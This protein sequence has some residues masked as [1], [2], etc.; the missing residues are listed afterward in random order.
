MPT[1]LEN[2]DSDL[3]FG[4]ASALLGLHPSHT[5]DQKFEELQKAGFRYCEVLT[6][7]YIGWVRQQKPELPESTCPP[8]WAE[9]REPDPSDS[10]IWAAL[11]TFAPKFTA[12][13]NQYGLT[14]IVL[15][16]LNHFEGWPEGHERE[17]WSRRKAERWLSL[18]AEL[19]VE[20]LQVGANDRKDASADD[21]KTASDMRWLADLGAKQEPPV[22]IAYE[23]W[24]FGDLRGDWEYTY[25]V[26]QLADH[27]NLG[28]CL[29]TAQLALSPTYGWDPLTGTGW[30]LPE[31]TSMLTRLRALPKDKIFYLE[32]SDVLQPSPPLY[33]G[34][35]FD[36]SARED[37]KGYGKGK[38]ARGKWVFYARPVPLVGPNGGVG[39]GDGGEE[40]ARRVGE[41][42]AA[43]VVETLKA[44]F[45]TGWRGYCMFEVFESIY[46]GADDPD[47][48]RRYA[49]AC[50][51][52]KEL[53]LNRVEE[54]SGSA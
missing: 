42:D 41:S 18:C 37:D 26:V 22:K 4:V 20:F 19:G 28:L 34:S 16:P 14:V 12:L 8:A 36:E 43:R 10:E 48:P 54:L 23:C 15:Q 32:L 52:S 2:L 49:Q 27:P 47:V 3:K 31:Y 21:E 53:L 40:E 13:A 25:K 35:K 1:R 44:I 39:E 9:F 38:N 46:M 17:E 6:A 51:K 24:C 33:G 50:R 29:D 45:S 30:S 5:F 7:D 11:S